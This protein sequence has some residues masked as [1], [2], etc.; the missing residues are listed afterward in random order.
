MRS[1]QAQAEALRDQVIAWRCDLH[2]HPEIAFEEIRT[3]A[4]V[5]QILND[6]RMEVQTGVGKTGV[7][8]ILEGEQDG[9]TVLVRADMDA[10]P[11]QEANQTP[12]VS[13]IP[14][15]MHACGHDAHTAIALGMAT[16]LAEHRHHLAGRIKFVFQPAEE[17]GAGA[18]A[19]IDDGALMNPVP[20]VSLGLHVWN[21]L[22]VGQV[23]II[24]GP[25]M[26]GVDLFHMRI[27]GKGGHAAEPQQTHDP[28]VAAAQIVTVAQTIISRNVRPLDAAVVSFTQVHAGD[29]YNVIPPVAEVGGTI[30]TFKP[31][32][33]E[34]VL[35]RLQTLAD[36]IARAMNCTATFEIRNSLPPLVNDPQVSQQLREGFHQIAPHLHLIDDYRTMGSEDMGLFLREVPGVFFFVGSAN[37]ER[38]L[39]FPHHHP[40]FDIDEEALVVGLSLLTS[41]VADYVWN[42]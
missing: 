23:A 41:A 7:V 33:R 36:G 10:L 3:A 9:P 24:E 27:E 26:A 29:A 31:E 40:R 22:S 19:M 18:R 15:K 4:F 32:I 25:A 12:Y 6:L 11:V 35:E 20:D 14:G 21:S 39:N 37:H 17:I 30:R 1:F 2:R 16:I 42:K 28:V 13:T 8:G 5:A 34:L 38:D